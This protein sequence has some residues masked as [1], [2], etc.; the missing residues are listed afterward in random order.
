MTFVRVVVQ[1][2]LGTEPV[3]LSALRRA[4]VRSVL[5]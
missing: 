1:F 2:E 3:A 4:V 5:H